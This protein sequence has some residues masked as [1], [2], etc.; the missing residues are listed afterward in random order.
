MG[1]RRT[2]DRD[3]DDEYVPSN[4]NILHGDLD[5]LNSIMDSVSDTNLEVKQSGKGR[6]LLLLRC[7]D[8]IEELH[9]EI[10]EER[11]V[12]LRIS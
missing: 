10:E 4:L 1:T 3:T 9:Q 6:D 11:A 5:E 7:R 8:A 12:K 2:A